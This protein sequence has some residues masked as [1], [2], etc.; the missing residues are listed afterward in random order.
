VTTRIRGSFDVK[1]TPHAPADPSGAWEPGRMAIDKHFHGALQATSQ[2]TMLAVRTEEEG[3]AGYVAIERVTGTLDGREGSFV[4]QHSGIM[5]RGAK[6]LAI[7]VV[8]G[9]GT[10]ALAGLRGTMDIIITDAGHEYD[11]EYSIESPPVGAVSSIS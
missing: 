9:S 5:D 8:P 3:S 7:T 2:G 4:L 10:G 11:F 6:Q 1:L